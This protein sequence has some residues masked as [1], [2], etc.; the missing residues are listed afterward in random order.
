[1]GINIWKRDPSEINEFY[2]ALNISKFVC[3]YSKVLIL[4]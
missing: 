1:M 3:L 2:N 4:I